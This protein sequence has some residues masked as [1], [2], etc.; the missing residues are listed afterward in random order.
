[1]VCYVHVEMRRFECPEQSDPQR[2]VHLHSARGG[3]VAQVD[4]DA[5]SKPV[6]EDC[7]DLCL[8][9]GIVPAE[10]DVV[11]TGNEAWIHHHLC[12]D[13]VECLYDAHARELELNQLG[14]RFGV[15]DRQ[16]RRHAS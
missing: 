7:C 9:A 11:L 3:D 5:P 8:C 14:E 4:D 1:C 10:K 13:G 6:A 15:A 12:V 16:G 2:Q